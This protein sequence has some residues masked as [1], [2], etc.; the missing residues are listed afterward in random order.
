MKLVLILGLLCLAGC[1]TQTPSRGNAPTYSG[2]S[3]G[4]YTEQVRRECAM[5][6]VEEFRKNPTIDAD[7]LFMFCVK[8]LGVRAI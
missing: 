1:T 8:E 3:S 6:A 5:A 2:N 7:G 4:N